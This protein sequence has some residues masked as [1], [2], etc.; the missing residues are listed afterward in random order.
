M[1]RSRF[2]VHP[3]KADAR[4]APPSSATHQ[5]RSIMSQPARQNLHREFDHVPEIRRP[6]RPRLRVHVEEADDSA[7]TAQPLL[8]SLLERL[9]SRNAVVGM[10]GLGYVGLPFAVEKAKVGFKVIGIEH[11][12][13]RAAQV[14]AG[15]NYIPDV[16]DEELKDLVDRGLLEAV[17]DYSR[18]PEMDVVVIAVPTPLTK[19]LNPDLQFVEIV[20]KE[21]SKVVR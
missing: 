8:D 13:A 18:V 11:N 3:A 2:S 1:D 12:K 16:S 9:H 17:T 7:T 14:N 21:L 19:N 6:D 10:V 4:Q 5:G 15:D 20:S